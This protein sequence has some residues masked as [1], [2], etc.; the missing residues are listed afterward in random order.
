[1]KNLM[2]TRVSLISVSNS[3]TYAYVCLQVVRLHLSKS[4]D[5]SFT[6]NNKNY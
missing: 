6:D 1:M 4:W 2:K 5:I 3:S